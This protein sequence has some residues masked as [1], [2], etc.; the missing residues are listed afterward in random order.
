M[1]NWTHAISGLLRRPAAGSKAASRTPRLSGS[2]PRFRPKVHELEDRTVPSGSDFFASAT[3]LT[4]LFAADS[5]SNVAATGETGEPNPFG[6]GAVNSLWW[7]W[8][9]P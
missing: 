3:V 1:N 5:G 9:A 6:D 7:Q 8:T 4:G 2:P